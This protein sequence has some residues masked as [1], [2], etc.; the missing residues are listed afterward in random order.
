MVNNFQTYFLDRDKSQTEEFNRAYDV[1]RKSIPPELQNS[2]VNTAFILFRPDA[3]LRGL[4]PEIVNEFNKQGIYLVNFIKLKLSQELLN[5]LYIFA[6]LKYQ[7]TW[8]IAQKMYLLGPSIPCLVVGN[9]LSFDHLSEKIRDLI[10]PTTPLLGTERQ[11]RT[12]YRGSNKILNLIHASDD[13]ASSF[14]EA[15]VFFDIDEIRKAIFT[16]KII[17]EAAPQNVINEL[18]PSSAIMDLIPSSII[19]LRTSVIKYKV[20]KQVLTSALKFLDVE[21][22]EKYKNDLAQ[23]LA[24]LAGTI[25]REQQIILKNLSLYDERIVLRDPLVSQEI[26][27]TVLLSDI[28]SLIACLGRTRILADEKKNYLLYLEK[29]GKCLEIIRTLSS[30]TRLLECDFERDILIPLESLDVKLDKVTE[31]VLQSIWVA[32][33]EESMACENHPRNL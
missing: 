11:I 17:S 14:R 18:I 33:K 10:G 2:I 15:S 29:T 20:K 30:E 9:H 1:F 7:K 24:S 19:D 4:I 16:A 6:K 23:S 27:V 13:P 26:L 25:E 28:S 12:K 22:C 8:W 3:Y 32:I 5:S 21:L 31:V